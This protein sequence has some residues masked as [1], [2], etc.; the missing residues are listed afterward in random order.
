[1]ATVGVKGSI[2]TTLVQYK[3]KLAKLHYSADRQ[4]HMTNV[5]DLDAVSLSDRV[6]QRIKVE[7]RQIW[8]LR[9]DEHHVW[10]VIPVTS[11]ADKRIKLISNNAR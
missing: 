9:L 7:R 3:Q 6:D 10:K 2:C 11:V 1:M 8:I 4:T 5:S